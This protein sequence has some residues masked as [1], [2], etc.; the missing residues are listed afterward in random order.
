MRTMSQVST[1]EVVSEAGCE[2]QSSRESPRSVL[3]AVETVP[4]WGYCKA[5]PV[6]A[7]GL[8][9]E[10]VGDSPFPRPGVTKG[11]FPK[12]VRELR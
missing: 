11:S 10:A 7:N 8:K 5:E 12:G 1:S 2:T 4:D 9:V 3:R 6:T